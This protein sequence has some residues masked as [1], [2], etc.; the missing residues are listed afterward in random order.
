ML[1]SRTIFLFIA[2]CLLITDANAQEI[3]NSYE[4]W[5]NYRF[6]KELPA[7]PSIQYVMVSNRYF[8]TIHYS[9][10]KRG[11][12]PERKLFYFVASRIGD[13]CYLTPFVN[14]ASAMKILPADR[15]FLIFVNGHGKNFERNLGRGF[16]LDERYQIN[17]ILFEWPTDNRTL[18]Q[19]VRNARKVT[20][21]FAGFVTEFHQIRN[22]YFSES[23]AS[24][25]FH[26]MGN[27]IARNLAKSKKP[28][29][30]KNKIFDNLALNAAA[31]SQCGHAH[32][33]EKLK[34]QDRI[35][36]ISNKSDYPLHG[37]WLLRKTIPL[38]MK[39]KSPHAKNA[40]YID[41]SLVAG[42]AHNYYAGR[43]DLEK[44]NQHAYDFYHTLFH[45]ENVNTADSIV[46][47]EKKKGMGF[48]IY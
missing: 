42:E 18:S 30:N 26:S 15:D 34:I 5:K 31:V 40:V 47:K 29:V 39:A 21:N 16:L 32:W 44:N 46:F 19:T 1:S 11:V 45:G 24:V 13:S 38:G 37:V 6:V 2:V 3:E 14:I 7:N 35:Y 28:D 9:I 8:D 22:Q 20:P 25:I 17:V 33:V 41:F 12:H 27:Q 10:V 4:T 48:Y 43:S 36:I 23:H